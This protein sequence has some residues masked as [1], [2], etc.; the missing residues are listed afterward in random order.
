M[1]LFVK[2]IVWREI[3]GN[4]DIQT[5]CGNTAITRAY[6]SGLSLHNPCV[7]PTLTGNLW[8]FDVLP[9]QHFVMALY[10]NFLVPS[11]NHYT[12]SGMFDPVGCFLYIS[13]VPTPGLVYAGI[14]RMTGHFGY[15]L[16]LY[17]LGVQNPALRIALPGLS[18]YWNEPVD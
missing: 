5:P 3:L 17:C 4:I 6:L 2:P 15:Y 7:N 11:S 12:V 8:E 14:V 16:G 1:R 13:G 18:G 9:N 10:P